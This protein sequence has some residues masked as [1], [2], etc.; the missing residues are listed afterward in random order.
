MKELFDWVLEMVQEGQLVP[1]PN[2]KE[3]KALVETWLEKARRVQWKQK[4]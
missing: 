4:R 1:N 3:A 2:D